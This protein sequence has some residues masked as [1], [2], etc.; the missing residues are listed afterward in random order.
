M[1]AP[2]FLSSMASAPLT[3]LRAH[4]DSPEGRHTVHDG[5]ISSQLVFLPNTEPG[6]PVAA[7]IPLDD[8]TLGRIEALVR[9]WRAW[10]S[11]PVPP[12]TRITVQQRRR[13]RLM[14][15][16]ADGR[17]SGA[18][19]REIAIALYGQTRVASHPWKTSPLRDAVVG[20]VKNGTAMIGGGYLQ[21]LRHRRRL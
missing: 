21:L 18:S 14:M 15:Q 2:D 5:A 11:R 12:D 13:L 10:Q 19:Y 20:L 16:T 8:Q 3:G 6:G 1:P 7:V 9:F 17:A 4:R